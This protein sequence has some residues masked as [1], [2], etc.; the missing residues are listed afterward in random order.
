MSMGMVTT[1]PDCHT[2][3]RLTLEQLDA[4]GGDV[5]CGRC[6]RVFD[7]RDALD[8]EEELPPAHEPPAAPVETPPEPEVH[9]QIEIPPL[10]GLPE[11][12]PSGAPS[13]PW[14][15]PEEM[16][17]AEAEVE[18]PEVEVEQPEVEAEQPEVEAEQPEVEAEHAAPE[19]IA[20]RRSRSWLWGIGSFVLLLALA[21]QGG[22]SY[23]SDLAARQPALKPYLEQLCS[24]FGCRI[25]LPRYPDLLGIE[26]SALE[27]DPDHPNVVALSAILRNRAGFVQAYPSLELTLTDTQDK[28]AGRRVLAPREYLPK[29]TDPSRGMPPNQEVA[30][31]LYLD[32]SALKAVGYRLYL[33]YP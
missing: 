33:F 20:P 5:R 16:A 25:P 12:T 28:P 22:Y 4:H 24:L 18:Q 27:A 30:V 17:G 31:K 11:I 13:I 8:F 14:P 19:E 29:G 10:E 7:A 21:L 3:F 6:G 32:F 23:R 26:T 15:E 2:T 1:C 9:E